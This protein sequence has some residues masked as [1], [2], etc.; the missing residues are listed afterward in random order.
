[1]INFTHNYILCFP[2]QIITILPITSQDKAPLYLRITRD[3]T[4]AP[5]F[6]RPMH[7]HNALE[8]RLLKYYQIHGFL[9][10]SLSLFL[11]FFLSIIFLF[12]VLMLSF[13]WWHWLLHYI[14]FIVIMSTLYWK[15]FLT[16][17]MCSNEWYQPMIHYLFQV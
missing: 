17:F 4:N 12:F 16:F 1:M 10:L 9:S 7:F 11:L 14:V 3:A 2:Y 8:S 6:Q 15:Q 5:S 13:Y